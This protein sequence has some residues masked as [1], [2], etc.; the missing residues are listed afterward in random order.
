MPLFFFILQEMLF[1]GGCFIEILVVLWGVLQ[2]SLISG[3]GAHPITHKLKNER[4]PLSVRSVGSV[5]D[6]KP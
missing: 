5:V 2:R 3:T 4:L 6:I 1:Y